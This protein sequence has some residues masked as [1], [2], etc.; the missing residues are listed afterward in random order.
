MKNA[1]KELKRLR[2]KFVASNMVMVTIVIV[3]AFLAVGYAAKSRIHQSNEQLLEHAYSETIPDFFTLSFGTRIPYFILV[4]NQEA[5]IL[6]VDGQYR[7]EPENEVLSYL[8]AASL[9][10]ADDRGFLKD[11]HLQYARRPF[12]SGYMIT[13]VD[14]SLGESYAS[15]TWKAL[16]IIGV[17]VW[18]SLFAVSCI[19]SK[20]AV[21]PIGQSI[22]REKQFVADASHELK[23]PLTVIMANAQLLEDSEKGLASGD[24]RR[25]LSNICQ[26]AAEMKK[27]V[28]EMLTLARNEAAG[29]PRVREICCLSDLATENVLSFEAVFYQAHKLL[30]SDIEENIL[31]KGD[32]KELSSLIRILLDNAQK[33]SPEGGKAAVLLRKC[34]SRKV[35]LTVTSTGEEIPAEQRK[36]IFDRFYRSD[37]SRTGKKGYGLG[38]AIAKSIA[39]SHRG[40]IGVESSAGEN[41]FFVEL[42]TVS[43]CE[44][45]AVRG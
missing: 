1:M 5:D 26:E 28:E 42:K 39:E 8:A 38:L 33:Y 30:E 32:E 41:R 23:T 20:W 21:A 12:E 18:L 27:L 36:V 44:K 31:V 15:G 40:K 2:I 13:Y 35:R 22:R 3:L 29:K 34:G 6:R 25:W 9:A 14:T 7:L 37:M 10:A 24:S 16:A 45:V 4:T 19:L 43:S 17:A 11:Y